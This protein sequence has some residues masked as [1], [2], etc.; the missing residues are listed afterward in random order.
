MVVDPSCAGRDAIE[1]WLDRPGHR[2]DLLDCASTTR[3]I[4]VA[5][6]RLDRVFVTHVPC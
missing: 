3:E 6:D 1:G 4:G 5:V 2:R